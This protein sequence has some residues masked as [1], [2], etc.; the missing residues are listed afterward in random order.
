MAYQRIPAKAY[1]TL[2][3]PSDEHPGPNRHSYQPQYPGHV[4]RRKVVSFTGRL[5]SK[6][7]NANHCSPMSVY[8]HSRWE[9]IKMNTQETVGHQDGFKLKKVSSYDDIGLRSGG[10]LAVRAGNRFG[11]P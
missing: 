9:L 2:S 10:D 7:S 6:D 1:S 5:T 11:E 3:A 4:G 8:M